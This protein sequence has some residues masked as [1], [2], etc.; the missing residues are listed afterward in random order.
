MPDLTKHEVLLNELSE[1]QT[2]VAELIN[3]KKTLLEEKTRLER[4]FS[5]LREENKMLLQQIE[6]LEKNGNNSLNSIFGSL[7]NN[8][9]EELKNKIQNL[10]NR[11]D[12]HLSS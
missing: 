11:I 10:V 4:S 5:G 9:K 1:I 12:L 7:D 3:S 6:A 2:L 8:E